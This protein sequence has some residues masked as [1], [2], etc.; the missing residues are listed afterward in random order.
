MD[1]LP[2]REETNLLATE[3]LLPGLQYSQLYLM[4]LNRIVASTRNNLRFLV[5]IQSLTNILLHVLY[6]SFAETKS[7]W[8]R[9]SH[10]DNINSH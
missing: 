3:L 7:G 9:F 2:L 1:K 4:V 10:R 6:F 5:F 8:S